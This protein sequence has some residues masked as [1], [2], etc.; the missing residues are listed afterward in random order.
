MSATA[1]RN[2][3]LRQTRVAQ[4]TILRQASS[5]SQAT[6][7]ASNTASKAKDSAS[8]A[9]SKASQGLSKVTSSAGPA[10][11]GATQ[12]VS[13]I[14]GRIGGRT[15]RLIS[16]V[17]CK[18]LKTKLS[19]STFWAI[20]SPLHLKAEVSMGKDIFVLHI[21]LLRYFMDKDTP[22]GF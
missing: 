2:F 16:F 7:A 18:S 22:G 5:S 19:K 8:K 17:Q 11:S 4:R 9:T 12:R 3:F 13:S 21:G 20:I 10:L 6:G 1:F 14:I 15:G